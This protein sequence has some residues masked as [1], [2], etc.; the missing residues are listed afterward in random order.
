MFINFILEMVSLKRQQVKANILLEA[1]IALAIFAMISS[2]L[3]GQIQNS[4]KEQQK[5]L[6]EEEKLRVVK[7]AL[8]TGESK[9]TVN[10][11]TVEQVKTDNSLTIYCQGE[12]L[13]RVTKR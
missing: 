11:I 4:R 5:L 10:N 9:L 13:L 2:I 7:M 12:E 3:L 1:V 8:Q 6:E